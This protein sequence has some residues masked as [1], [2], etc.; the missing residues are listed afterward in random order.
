[1]SGF[2]NWRQ[3]EVLTERYVAV[4]LGD[5]GNTLLLMAQVPVI[6]GLIC[7]SWSQSSPDSKL[8]FCVCLAAIF[9]G[10]MNACREV[11]K[12]RPLYQ[13]ERMVNLE[14]PAYIVSKAQVLCG[15]NAVQCALLLGMVVHWVG[16]PGTKIFLFLSIWLG[17]MTGT[18]VGLCISTAVKSSDQAVALAPVALIPQIIF[19]KM[20]LPEGA[21]HGIV[22]W[23]ERLN[24]LRWTH[25]LYEKVSDF[26]REPAWGECFKDAGV[27]LA[28]VVVLL[29]A[30]MGILWMQEE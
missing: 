15:L 28:L 22:E 9:L 1:M 19:T 8:Y 2:V 24:P 29:A 11:V 3:T 16:L 13:R 23:I 20:I 26:A 4:M 27:L 14:I 30:A 17:A 5:L 7:L 10:C 6:G 18:M 21:S 25:D 12:E